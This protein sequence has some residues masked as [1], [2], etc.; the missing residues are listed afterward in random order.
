MEAKTKEAR[1]Q[2]NRWSKSPQLWFGA[3]HGLRLRS[4]AWHS[5]ALPSRTPHMHWPSA[6]HDALPQGA[7]LNLGGRCQ[8]FLPRPSGESDALAPLSQL[9]PRSGGIGNVPS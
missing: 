4:A 3:R 9:T 1:R 6:R 7:N 2:R 8:G 5:Y